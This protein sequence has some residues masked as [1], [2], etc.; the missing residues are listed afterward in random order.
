MEVN[1]VAKYNSCIPEP[2]Q[3]ITRSGQISLNLLLNAV[4]LDRRGCISP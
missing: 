2:V 3:P 4:A 1:R